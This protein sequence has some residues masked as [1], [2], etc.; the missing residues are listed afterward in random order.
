MAKWTEPAVP[1]LR[2]H[3]MPAHW[4]DR[5]THIPAGPNNL[6]HT[7]IDKPSVH[8]VEDWL[9]PYPRLSALGRPTDVSSPEPTTLTDELEKSYA[10]RIRWDD[11]TN[12]DGLNQRDWTLGR[13]DV[14]YDRSFDTANGVAR[15]AVGGNAHTQHLLVTWWL[16]L[17]SLSMLARYFQGNGPRY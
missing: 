5:R 6:A 4:A 9:A 1:G 3:P 12:V 13:V 16:V 2:V 10:V 14:I 17:Y 8:E 15:P 11:E 7:R